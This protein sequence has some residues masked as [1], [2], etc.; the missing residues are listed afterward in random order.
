VEDNAELIAL[1]RKLTPKE[2]ETLG[3]LCSGLTIK[4]IAARMICTQ[5]NVLAHLAHIYEKLGLTG[6]TSAVRRGE[7]GKFCIAFQQMS[8]ADQDASSVPGPIADD[9]PGAKV[10]PE[11]EL[12]DVSKRALVAVLRDDDARF[13]ADLQPPIVESVEYPAVPRRS[14]RWLPSLLI[15]FGVALLS[16]L[17]TELIT[18]VRPSGHSLL[19]EEVVVTATPNLA[20]AGIGPTPNPPATPEPSATAIPTVLPTPTPMPSPTAPPTATALTG[21]RSLAG[22]VPDDIPGVLV[23]P[24]VTISSVVDEHT[25]PRDVY[26]IRLAAGQVLQFSMSIQPGRHTY[27]I[28]IADPDM[29]S[30]ETNPWH[31]SSFCAYDQ[32]SCSDSFTPA[33]TGTYYLGVVALSSNVPYTLRLNVR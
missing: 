8:Q 21:T 11:P 33:A 15:L 20:L 5:S 26:A 31:G 18:V 23:A 3:W 25:K 28:E 32:I 12:A 4:E 16:S 19:V 7:I 22:K 30:F 24:G 14:R 1:L 29:V 10:E 6:Y 17:L 2:R 27:A 13:G 9:T